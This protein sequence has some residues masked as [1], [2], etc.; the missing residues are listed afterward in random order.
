[1]T[2]IAWD[3]MTLAGDRLGCAGD[4]KR[5]VTKISRVGSCLLGTAGS[6]VHAVEFREWLLSGADPKTIPL[7]QLSEEYQNVIL[8]KPDKSCWVY[9]QGV[10]P[11]L[12]E[13]TFHACGSG[14]DFAL[15]AMHMGKSA[16][17]AVELASLFDVA[18]GN[19]VDILTL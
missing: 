8:I 10:Y 5:T 19:G 2:T 4:L 7:F 12:V 14:R 1:M 11:S 9:S 13:D 15:A 18:T 16:K 17:E 6:A 3:G